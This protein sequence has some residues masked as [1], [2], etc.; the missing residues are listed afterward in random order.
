LAVRFSRFGDYLYGSAK[1]IRLFGCTN[2]ENHYAGCI[3]TLFCS[4]VRRMVPE[5]GKSERRDQKGNVRQ[6]IIIKLPNC[7]GVFLFGA[8]PAIHCIFFFFLLKKKK[9]AVPIGARDFVIQTRFY[10]KIESC[11]SLEISVGI[12]TYFLIMSLL[13]VSAFANLKTFLIMSKSSKL[14]VQIISKI[15]FQNK[16]IKICRLINYSYF[17]TSK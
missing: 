7:S 6:S 9:D 11:Y 4:I 10:I 8:I 1:S 5:A 17:C 12:Q 2:Q 14:C 15:N 16:A 3:G 13:S